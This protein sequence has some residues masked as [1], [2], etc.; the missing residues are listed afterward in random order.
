MIACHRINFF[1]SCGHN[2]LPAKTIPNTKKF[3]Q[4]STLSGSLD[5]TRECALAPGHS[6]ACRFTFT[7][8]LV[9]AQRAEMNHRCSKM[10]ISEGKSIVSTRFIHPDPDFRQPAFLPQNVKAHIFVDHSQS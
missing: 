4:I 3:Q 8:Q 6:H 2:F 1:P 9:A 7:L 10:N 5:G